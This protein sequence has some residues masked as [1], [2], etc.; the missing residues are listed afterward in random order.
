MKN[1]FMRIA[2]VMLMLCLV[3]T[4]AISGTFAKYTTSV[5]GDDSARVAYWGWNTATLNIDDLFKSAYDSDVNSTVDVI[6]PGTTG[7]AT[8]S[9]AYTNNNNGT[10]ADTS[11]DITAP[12]VD[13][14]FT[15]DATASTIATDIKAN[16]NILW[17]FHKQGETAVWGGWDAMISAIN[18]L[19]Q[20]KVEANNLPTNFAAGTTYVIE[21]QWKFSSDEA[22][23]VADTALGNK[24]T[25]D[26]VAVVISISATQ[27]TD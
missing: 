23:D 15:V 12:E 9:V 26:K 22:G 16:T 21:W 10:D 27:L 20:E 25:L 11:D 7:S 5:S 13:Y 1:K 17:S 4:C 19:S 14:K 2:A 8:F 3:T 18:A 6:A 24:A